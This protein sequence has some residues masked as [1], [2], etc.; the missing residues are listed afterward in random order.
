MLISAYEFVFLIAL[1]NCTMAQDFGSTTLILSIVTAAVMCVK[2]VVFNII[3]L[4]LNA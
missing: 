4:L 3:F 2:P 1:N